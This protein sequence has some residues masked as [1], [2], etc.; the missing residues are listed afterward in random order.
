[1]FLTKTHCVSPECIFFFH[2]RF[3]SLILRCLHSCL[4]ARSLRLHCLGQLGFSG[5]LP[6]PTVHQWNSAKPLVWIASPCFAAHAHSCTRNK[7]PVRTLLNSATRGQKLHGAPLTWK[8]G[9]AESISVKGNSSCVPVSS[10]NTWRTLLSH[11][12]VRNRDAGLA[13]RWKVSVLT[14]APARFHNTKQK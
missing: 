14:A 6:P 3:A 2:K 9:K 12:A 13:R 8:C 10:Y 11:Q 5:T 7:T 1:M 4:Q